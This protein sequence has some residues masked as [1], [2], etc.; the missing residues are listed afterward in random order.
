ME[1]SISGGWHGQYGFARSRATVNIREKAC[2]S[3]WILGHIFFAQTSLDI[4]VVV[5]NIHWG[6]NNGEKNYIGYRY[7][8]SVNCQRQYLLA[9]LR[10]VKF[11]EPLAQWEQHRTVSLPSTS[12]S[13]LLDDC[14]TTMVLSFSCQCI[15]VYFVYHIR[16]QQR[17][18]IFTIAIFV[19]CLGLEKALPNSICLMIKFQPSGN[20]TY[21]DIPH[22]NVSVFPHLP[23][24]GC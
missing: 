4:D 15:A 14:S 16:Q 3:H 11:H 19:T 9:G 8:Q 13:K 17:I 10:P 1:A 24:E 18:S 2:L 21:C 6:T 20:L 23:G 12:L 22:E 7:P 5:D